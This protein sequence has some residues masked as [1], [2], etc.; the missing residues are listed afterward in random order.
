MHLA[1]GHGERLHAIRM[2]VQQ[3]A[4]IRGRAMCRRDGEHHLRRGYRPVDA[5]IGTGAIAT[6]DEPGRTRGSSPAGPASVQWVPHGDDVIEDEDVRRI[7]TGPCG[8]FASHSQ[9][10]DMALPIRESILSARMSE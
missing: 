3:E 6:W 4:E 1:E 9:E 7:A 10:R 2:L 8:A 5:W